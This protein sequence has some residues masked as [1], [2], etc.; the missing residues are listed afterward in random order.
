MLLLHSLFKLVRRNQHAG[1]ISR[2]RLKT[3]NRQV[4]IDLRTVV[5]NDP[6]R[7]V[8]CHIGISDQP[9]FV[10]VFKDFVE[11]AVDHIGNMHTFDDS[12]FI[13]AVV[14]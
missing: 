11:R 7:A 5:V 2:R 1:T 12:H 6:L 9:F 10:A 3:V 8:E 4:F 13:I 14:E